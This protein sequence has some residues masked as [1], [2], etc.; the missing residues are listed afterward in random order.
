MRYDADAIMN[1]CAPQSMPPAPRDWKT[2][3]TAAL[4]L[5]V[6]LGLFWPATGFDFIDFDDGGY[7]YANE[8][9]NTGLAWQEV[10]WAFTT[11]HEAWWLPMLW[12]SFMVD[13]ELFGP[14][15]F[16]YHLTNIVL[17]ALNGVL[18][19]WV[20][21]RMTGA[22][23]RS[24][25]AAALFLVHPLR[26]ES[27][28]WIT[29][30]KDVLSGLF[31]MLALLAHVRYVERPARGRYW[32]VP[33]W[34]LLGLMSKAIVVALPP[35]LL[36][37]D[38]WPLGRAGSPF[39]RDQWPAWGRLVREKTPLILLSL[40]FIGIN[41]KTHT[42]GSGF[43]YGLTFLNRLLLIFPNYW[44]Y[45]AKIVWPWPMGILYP[46]N[47]RVFGPASLL[48][49]AG[50]LALTWAAFRA[51]RRRRY[52]GM[53]WLWFGVILFP[54]IRGV[55]LGLAEYADRF[56]Y[57]PAIGLGVILVW[58]A[59]DWA[60]NR[61][62]R[63]ALA[64]GAAGLLLA[65]WSGGT[66]RQIRRWENSETLFTHTLSFTG[67]NPIIRNNLGGYWLER[68]RLQEAEQAF[69]E[70]IELDPG[71]ALPQGNLGAVHCIA[72]RF[73]EALDPLEAAIR[74]D[75]EY[76][77]AVL[78]LG[79]A[80]YM[81]GRFEDAKARFR[82]VLEMDPRAAGVAH[83]NIGNALYESGRFEEAVASYEAALRARPRY[84]DAHCNLG[85]AYYRLGRLP[86]A[87]ASFAAALAQQ[88]N[89]FN[90]V[91]N[92]ANVQL[93]QGEFAAAE[94]G[95]RRATGLQP[96]N[97]AGF[98][99]LGRVARARNDSAQ[100]LEHFEAALTLDAN[101]AA[102]LIT[103]GDRLFQQGLPGEA[104]QRYREVIL[105]F[106]ENALA[107]H[108]LGNALSALNRP[109]EALE[110]F[111]AAL[112]IDPDY[113]LAY[114][115]RG[116]VRVELGRFDEAIR[117]YEAAR[118]LDPDHLAAA[119]NQGRALCATERLEPALDHFRYA[120]ERDPEH[121]PATIN[122][123]NALYQLGRRS[124]AEAMAGRALEL[125]VRQGDPDFVARTRARLGTFSSAGAPAD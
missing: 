25:L 124:E 90:T 76:K 10:R 40:V 93:Q 75:P 60:G 88:S 47:D 111:T 62:G 66:A 96:T 79:G 110:A 85:N 113:M 44:K 117:D 8:W 95:Y 46:E 18:L 3:L 28:V 35:A 99:G 14:G 51:S 123:E 114:F 71:F 69:R 57:L 24:A 102:R 12:M 22:R 106:P 20:F 52:A 26:V 103:E 31:W 56:T 36:L 39:R 15:P 87:R 112:E 41:L 48:A 50:L 81:L 89:H 72:G 55:R 86:E 23:G 98:V 38:Y 80:L 91:Q 73:E 21:F 68:G 116:N 6:G 119:I 11:V 78:N 29:E 100:A 118:R 27:V 84:P 9:V 63:R 5:A 77:A 16:G 83:Y 45:L 58:A 19:F 7:V 33:L 64:L 2:L 49:L 43:I 108:N 82:Q 125:A 13:T 104:A 94:E 37:L 105:L 67:A 109:A 70:V 1:A 17:H 92:L 97:A 101:L 120:L 4:L 61:R 107:H 122:L 115:N 121:L 54:V 42:T 30:R 53:G 59:A 32:A 74:L 34:M 65:A